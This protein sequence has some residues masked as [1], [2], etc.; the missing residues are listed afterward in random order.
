M[1]KKWA[2]YRPPEGERDVSLDG[3]FWQLSMR[4]ESKSTSL[5]RGS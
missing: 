3:A 4:T 1:E 2:K 5:P